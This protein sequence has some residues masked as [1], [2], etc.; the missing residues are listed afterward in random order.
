MRR[1]LSIALALLLIVA[2][3]SATYLRHRFSR[4]QRRH[5]GELTILS[6]SLQLREGDLV[7]QT[8]RSAQSQAIQLATHSPYSHCGMLLRQGGEWQVLEAV[9]PVRLTPLEQWIGR[10]R[11]SH[12]VVKR[13]R[14]ADQV[15]TPSTLRQLRRTG[16][17]Y[18]GR[19]YDL[20]F[21]WSNERIYCSELL[22]KTYQ[23]ATG[24]RIG[25]L[26]Q[27]REFDL[28]HPAVQQKLRERYGNRLPLREPVIS[29]VAMFDSP[30]LVKVL[31]R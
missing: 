7:F 16:L 14:D 28:S 13:L 4:F 18:Q 17:Q 10:G 21:G 9:Q 19:A 15:L 22:W 30:E 8:S 3:V 12:F 2:A 11:G 6:I 5:R 24:R 20:Y 31:Q 26:Q 25:R 23:Q 27:L 1:P 29:P